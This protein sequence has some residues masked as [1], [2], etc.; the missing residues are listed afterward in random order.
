MSQGPLIVVFVRDGLHLLAKAVD[1][2]QGSVARGGAGAISR[3]EAANDHQAFLQD[4][5]CG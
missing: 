4:C 5:Q 1:D 3:R 2:Q